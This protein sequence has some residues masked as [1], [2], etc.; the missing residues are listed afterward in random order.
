M[1]HTVSKEL[2]SNPAPSSSETEL[3]DSAAPASADR[4]SVLRMI[5]PVQAG[6]EPTLSS[7]LRRFRHV[8]VLNDYLRIP[9]ANGSSF[10]SQFIY[11]ELRKR[12]HDVTV[13]GPYDAEAKPEDLPKEHLA[14][15]AFPLRMHPG[16]NMSM[17]R[18][19]DYEALRKANFDAIICQSSS[20]LMEYGV[21]LRRQA[22]VPLVCEHGASTECVQSGST[23]C[24]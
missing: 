8:G 6:P 11:R 12:G 14:M 1:D 24:A 5:S 17:P 22:G 20:A 2:F 9:Y 4:D 18:S 13:L 16:V 10:A 3:R 7:R 23:G 21:W 15:R 19:S